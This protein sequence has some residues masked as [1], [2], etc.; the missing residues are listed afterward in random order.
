MTSPYQILG[1]TEQVS[2]AEI[3]Q[4]YLQ[5][6]K[7]NP[8]D[9]DRKRFQQI[10]QA[11]EAIK[12]GDSRLRYAL[13]ELP[14]VGFNQLLDRAFRQESALPPLS[15]DD[16]FKLLR[17]VPVEKALSTALGAKAS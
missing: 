15:T 16:F 1:V 14:E 12:D 6:V 3:K 4:A 7:D 17:A 11:F 2:D 10:Q 13:F 8:P 5:Q 9:R